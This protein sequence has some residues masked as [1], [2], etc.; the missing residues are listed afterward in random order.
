MACRDSHD[1]TLRNVHYAVIATPETT[2][3]PTLSTRRA[4]S[5]SC[6]LAG[7]ISGSQYPNALQY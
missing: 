1:A 7:K 6:A 2:R 5:A 4:R 3:M